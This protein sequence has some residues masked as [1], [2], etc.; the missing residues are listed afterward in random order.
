MFY[1][2]KADPDPSKNRSI[3]I[4]QLRRKF[5][6]VGMCV[7]GGGIACQRGGIFGHPHGD[8]SLHIS[9]RSVVPHLQQVTRQLH[10]KTNP[11]LPL[12]KNIHHL[13]RP[14]HQEIQQVNRQLH[15]ET[16]PLLLPLPKNIYHQVL[17][18]YHTHP[19]H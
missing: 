10:P 7:G 5:Q 16:N 2:I 3:H 12:P 6:C 15:Q 14:S 4:L 18:K 8:M 11:L 1:K 19:A 9:T 17:K 13:P